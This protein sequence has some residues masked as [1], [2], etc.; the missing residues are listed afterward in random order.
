MSE[1]IYRPVSFTLIIFLRA[2]YLHKDGEMFCAVPIRRTLWHTVQVFAKP[3]KLLFNNIK[4]I[5][6]SDIKV[7]PFKRLAD[8]D[9]ISDLIIENMLVNTAPKA[10]NNIL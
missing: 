2:K 8:I 1:T 4:G 5:F 7:E 6:H 10:V 9:D 3:Y